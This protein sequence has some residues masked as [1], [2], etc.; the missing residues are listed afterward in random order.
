MNATRIKMSIKSDC[1]WCLG[2]ESNPHESTNFINLRSWCQRSAKVFL[3]LLLSCGGAHAGEWTRAD[4]A[5]EVAY[6]ALHVVDYSQTL[7]ISDN[8]N[9]W[10]EKN[11]IIGKHPSRGEVNTYFLITGLLHP[12]VAYVLPKPYRE[13]FQYSTIA[14]EIYCV[15]NNYSLGIG[16]RF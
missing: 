9:R 14:I 10:Y 5:R 11:P 8:P 2:R 3:I 13:I 16:G 12:A 7:E 4:T 6:L 15:G 1:Y